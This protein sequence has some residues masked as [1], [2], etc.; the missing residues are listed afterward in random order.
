M[1]RPTDAGNFAEACYALMEPLTYA[2]AETAQAYALLIL[3]GAIG[4]GG[5][6]EF[7]DLARYDGV[8][9]PWTRLLDINRIPDAGV[10]WLGQF[11]GVAVN[12]ALTPDEQRQ[13]IRALENWGRGRPDTIKKAI[14]DSGGLSGSQSVILRERDTSAY[15]F[16]VITYPDETIGNQTQIYADLYNDNATYGALLSQTNSYFG[17]YYGE[18]AGLVYDAI[19]S[20]KPAADQFTYS[21]T[22]PQDYWGIWEDFA[23]YSTIYNYGALT[24]QAIYDYLSPSAHAA[25]G[26]PQI[27]IYDIDVDYEEMWNEQQTYLDIYN[28][29]NRY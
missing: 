20:S 21:I 27:S 19:I 17:I 15:H 9:G 1:S 8:D 2:D 23:T 14:R 26:L 12:T 16:T 13:Q 11:A 24:Y 22:F 29:F 6:Q 5:F 7:D 28:T 10:P 3:L 4:Q 18:G 25:P